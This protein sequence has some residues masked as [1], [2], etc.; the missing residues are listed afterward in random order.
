MIHVAS[1]IYFFI[2]S[3]F[4]NP[5]KNYL[6]VALTISALLLIS[7]NAKVI[8]NFAFCTLENT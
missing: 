1:N 5:V 6:N 3:K 7:V 4:S 2:F 8:I